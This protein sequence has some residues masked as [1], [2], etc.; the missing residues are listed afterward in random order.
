MELGELSNLNTKALYQNAEQQL[1]IRSECFE[2]LYEL[3][4]SHIGQFF[5]IYS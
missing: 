5:V 3:V 2:K 4:C 1:Q